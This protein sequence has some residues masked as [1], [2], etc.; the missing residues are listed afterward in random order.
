MYFDEP[1]KGFGP[2]PVELKAVLAVSGLFNLLFFV[3]PGP[4]VEAATA[5]AKS[6]F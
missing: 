6:L 5:A 1:A 3:Y 4:L 2:M